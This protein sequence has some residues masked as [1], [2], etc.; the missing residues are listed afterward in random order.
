MLHVIDAIFIL[1]RKLKVNFEYICVHGF[2]T[3]TIKERC[4]GFLKS[5]WDQ[6]EI[7]RNDV[8]INLI[9]I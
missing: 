9:I 5:N 4:L 1:W 8:I 2:Q 6:I 3:Q 7:D